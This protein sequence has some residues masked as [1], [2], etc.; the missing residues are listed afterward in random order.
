MSFFEILA[1]A[2]ITY[3]AGRAIV[4]ASGEIVEAVGTMHA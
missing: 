3:Y 4:E 2:T 1:N